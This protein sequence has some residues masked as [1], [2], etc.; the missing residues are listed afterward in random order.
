MAVME[1]SKPDQVSQRPRE[2]CEPGE[3]SRLKIL[4]ELQSEISHL[5]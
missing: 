4:P 2:R 1:T 3:I 5:V